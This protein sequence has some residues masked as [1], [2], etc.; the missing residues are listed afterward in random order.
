MAAWALS[1]VGAAAAPLL[2]HRLGPGAAGCVL[3]VLQGSAVVAM[4]LAAGAVGAVVA[5]LVNYAAQGATNPVHYGMVHRAA[6]SAH[7]ATVVSANSL[8]SQAGGAAGG[9]A[10]GALADRTS[11]ST[12]MV[13]AGI[14]LAAAA[15][16]YLVGPGRPIRR[17]ATVARPGARAGDQYT[18]A[19]R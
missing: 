2:S 3:R 6:D 12:A 4:G 14:V 8:A 19:G 13:I 18:P 17:H 1:A 9:I 10:L 16:L 5:Y 11:I 7:R 15:P